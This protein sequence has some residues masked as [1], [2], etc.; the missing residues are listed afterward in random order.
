M[1]FFLMIRRPPRSTL[2]PYTTL[3]RSLVD[4]VAVAGAA[5]VVVEE[6]DLVLAEVALAL[7]RLHDEPGAGH[8]V[9][10]PAQQRLDPRRAEHGVVDVVLVGRCQAAVPGAPRLLVGVAEDDE[11]ELRADVGPHA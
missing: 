1:W 8:V 3:F 10:D 9:A 11:L 5:G 6:G 4:H 7:R 2:F